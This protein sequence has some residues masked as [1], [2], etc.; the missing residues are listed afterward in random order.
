MKGS[1]EKPYK[2]LVEGDIF[3]TRVARICASARPERCTFL[4]GDACNLEESLGTFDAVLAANLLCRLPDPRLFLDRLPTLL[5]EGAV[6]GGVAVLVSPFSWLPEYTPPEKWLGGTADG[7]RST[8]GLAKV[9]AQ[10]GF[11]LVS[12]SDV[13]FLIREHARKFQWGCSEATVWRLAR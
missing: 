2:S 3:E 6:G 7:A 1:G 4:Q 12:K 13:P 11:V 8:D 9:M 10:N 5:N